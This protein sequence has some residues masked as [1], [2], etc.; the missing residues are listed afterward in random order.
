MMTMTLPTQN[1]QQENSTLLMI[2]IMDSMAKEMKMTRLLNLKQKS[3]SQVFM[4]TQ[5]HTFL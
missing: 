4:I 1:L 3:K 5:R 2:R